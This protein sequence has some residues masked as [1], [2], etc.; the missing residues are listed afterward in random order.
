MIIGITIPLLKGGRHDSQTQSKKA[1]WET[2]Y[3]CW[4]NPVTKV[5]RIKGTKVLGARLN[6]QSSDAKPS[7]KDS[8]HKGK[9][10]CQLYF[11]PRSAGQSNQPIERP[12]FCLACRQGPTSTDKGY[13]HLKNQHTW[14]INKRTP[15]SA[16]WNSLFIS[17]LPGKRGVVQ[18]VKNI[19]HTTPETLIENSFELFRRM[20]SPVNY[21][22]IRL[23]HLI[24]GIGDRLPSLQLSIS[25][26]TR[27]RWGFS[28]SWFVIKSIATVLVTPSGYDH[29]RIVSWL[30]ELVVHRFYHA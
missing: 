26:S 1:R 10:G 20:K 29:I 25:P 30:D 28:Q 15:W 21:C 13:R 24:E 7:S 27:P 12:H 23:L 18:N 22:D 8:Q 16:E 11:H 6:C 2:F 14:S 3:R 19:S 4:Q 5:V 9:H 17:I